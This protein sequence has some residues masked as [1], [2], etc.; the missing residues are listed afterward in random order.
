MLAEERGVH[1]VI[2]SGLVG[3]AVFRSSHPLS[4]RGAVRAEVAQVT[5]T[6]SHVSPS[7]LVHEDDSGRAD[8]RDVLTEAR[9]DVQTVTRDVLTV[10]WDVLTVLL[11]VLKC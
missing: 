8:V 3:S 9:K 10:V 4:G 5:A 1:T 6:K 11:D 2:D 7:L